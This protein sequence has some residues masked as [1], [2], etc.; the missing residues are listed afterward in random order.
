MFGTHF[1]HKRVR[2]AVSVFGSL[3]NNLYVLR[4]NSAGETISQVKVPLSYAPKRNFLAR[5]EQMTN[6]EQNERLVAIKLPRM[7]FEIN[8][9]AYD[10]TRQLNK[11]NNLNKVL[12][13]STISRQKLFTATPY[14]I[15]FDLNVYAKSQDCLL[16][17]SPSPRD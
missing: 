8:G 15:N 1:Y 4:Q 11:M 12:A 13:G 7:S 9:I 6:G 3:F 14:N 2:S 10:E 17:T 16:Y 5:I